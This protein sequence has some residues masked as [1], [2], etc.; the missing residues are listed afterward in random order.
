MPESVAVE[1]VVS[2]LSSTFSVAVPVGSVTERGAKMPPTEV[3]VP[4]LTVLPPE[5][6]TMLIDWN[7][8]TAVMLKMLLESLPRSVAPPV[9]P[10]FDT[11][12]MSPRGPVMVD[13]IPLVERAYVPLPRL[14]SL[15]STVS[16]LP[17]SPG[18]GFTTIRAWTALADWL[19]VDPTVDTPSMTSALSPVWLMVIVTAGLAFRVSAGIAPHCVEKVAPGPCSTRASRRRCWPR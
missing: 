17:L 14:L 16:V 12:S 18:L 5:P 6:P 10:R 7:G 11:M 9:M 8:E 19:A 15:S 13:A 4:A 1:L 3:P 2:A